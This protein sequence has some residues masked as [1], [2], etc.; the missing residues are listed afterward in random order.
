MSG[1]SSYEK[2]CSTIDKDNSG[3]PWTNT[4]KRLSNEWC[5]IEI[6]KENLKKEG[7]YI[8][9]TD[10]FSTF[11]VMIFKKDNAGPYKYTPFC[12][13]I[14]PCRDDT[15]QAYPLIPPIV[16]FVSF[17]S[18]R[19]HPNI[20]PCGSI[21]ISALSYSYIGTGA[22]IWNPMMNIRSIANILSGLL[23]ESAL[24]Q[25]PGYATMDKR[26][27]KVLDFDEGIK[28]HCMSY[29]NTLFT[30]KGR[31]DMC[32]K[33]FSEVLE[34]C[35]DEIQQYIKDGCKDKATRTVSTYVFTTMLD[36]SKLV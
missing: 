14:K 15:G 19:I 4:L 36:Y 1:L 8:Q 24:L 16:R 22:A 9:K 29:L 18:T 6:D 20:K 23:D 13:T 17:T 7:I 3:L 28:Y 21:C 26:D 27:Q 30:D 10:D 12:F 11:T 25:E 35:K 34:P 5:K 33:L 2:N 32:R 31:N